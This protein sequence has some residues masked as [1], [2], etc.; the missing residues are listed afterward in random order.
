MIEDNIFM[1]TVFIIMFILDILIL[2][3]GLKT[4]YDMRNYVNCFNNSF[5]SNY[6]IIYR[7][8]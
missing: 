7:N 8:Y 3:I 1:E 5:T 6:C 2:I 4:Y